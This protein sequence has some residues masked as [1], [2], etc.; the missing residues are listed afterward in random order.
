MPAHPPQHMPLATRSANREQGPP[1]EQ[2]SQAPQAPPWQPPPRQQL[3]SVQPSAL[4]VSQSLVQ[5]PRLANSRALGRL[6]SRVIKGR[7]ALRDV[8]T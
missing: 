4:H 5:Q 2:P 3:P 7:G 8:A 1:Q 6:A